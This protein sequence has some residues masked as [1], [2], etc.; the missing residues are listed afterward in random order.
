MFLYFF[1]K[2]L[3][4]MSI[5][6]GITFMA[7]ILVRL[8]PGDPVEMMMGQNVL[9]ALDHQAALHHFGL[10][11]PL[12]HQY[13]LYIKN[14]LSGDF[15]LSFFTQ[16]SVLLEFF[17]CFSATFELTLSALFF[18]IFLG[19]PV[20]ILASVYRGRW[21]D[22]GIMNIALFG[23]SMPIFWWGMMLIMF[24]S[25]SLGLFPVSGRISLFYDVE[26]MTGFMLIDAWFCKEKGAWLS[27]VHHL[28]LP[29]FVL[30]TIPLASIAR[31]TRSAM[32]E[33]SKENYIRT[34]RAKG[35]SPL[36]V[37]FVHALRNA[38]IPII[39]AIG[40][41]AS[42]LFSGA[43]LTETIF[44]WPGVGKWLIDAISRRDYPI[45]QNGIVFVVIIV[46]LF[47]LC[48]ELLYRIV[49]PRIRFKK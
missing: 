22:H 35:L 7:F 30:G 17:S 19:V 14:F 15:G 31:M 9:N 37:I 25:V 1:R 34:A 11:R 12:I 42:S 38:I 26:P 44:S 13:F 36:T 43:V 6:F 5:F 32:L 39:V 28:M 46:I 33:V 24:L 4:L 21:I 20:G 3:S 29:S 16:E 8:I 27:A 48:S 41:Q 47:N 23:Y 2:S 10:D 49:N 18:A 40:L 45:V